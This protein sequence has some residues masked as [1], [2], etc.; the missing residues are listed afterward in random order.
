MSFHVFFL[1]YSPLIRHNLIRSTVYIKVN[2][3]LCEVRNIIQVYRFLSDFNCSSFLIF[4]LT[5]S[6]MTVKLNLRLGE[7]GHI[8]GIKH[9]HVIF[10]W[11]AL[12]QEERFCAAAII[13]D[14]CK[15]E[16]GVHTIITFT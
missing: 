14:A 12:G 15:I 4:Y 6:L 16:F 8:I 10:P 13:T 3:C 7:V 2:Q 1:D 9:L 5:D 11:I